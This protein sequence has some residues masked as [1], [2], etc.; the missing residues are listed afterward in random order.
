MNG[1]TKWATNEIFALR[2]APIQVSWLGYS[3]TSGATFI[4]YLITDHICSPSKFGEFYTEKLAY[5]NCSVSVGYHKQIYNDLNCHIYRNP[6][7]KENISLNSENN[8]K[9]CHFNELVSNI[10]T[11][12]MFCIKFSDDNFKC[13][14]RQIYNLPEDVI[15]YCNF[16][17]LFKIEPSTFQ[18]WANILHNVPNSVLW[19]LRSTCNGEQNLKKYAATLNIDVSRII[20]SNV[21]K[22]ENHLL[23]IQ[24][25][26]I[27]L[28]TPLYNANM[29]CLD[30]LWAGI[31]VITLPGNTL[32]SRVATSQL[33]TFGC[34]ETIAQSEEDYVQKAINYG[35]NKIALDSLK[36]KI[37][38]IKKESKLFDC[39]SYTEELENIYYAIWGNFLSE[40]I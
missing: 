19:L 29:T 23:R 30:V 17:Q 2:P 32:A 25:A 33:T 21:E 35:S 14:T 27:Y 11:N 1:Y 12:F 38:S 28:D 5:M 10:N 9:D 15:V 8:I 36:F 7:T 26:D 40:S 20:F 4:D 24:L 16:S 37:S 13:L 18:M 22:E 39:K 6:G 3:S 31:P 34:P